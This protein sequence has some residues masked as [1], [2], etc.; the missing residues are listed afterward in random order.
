[1]DLTL[2]TPALSNNNPEDAQNRPEQV[3]VWLQNLPLININETSHQLHKAL[4]AANRTTV[5]EEWRVQNLEAFREFVHMVTEKLE[6]KYNNKPLPL[7][8]EDG[9]TAELVRHFQI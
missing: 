4:M 9:M 7:S 2:S 5:K 1:M 6:Q 3:Q 8:E